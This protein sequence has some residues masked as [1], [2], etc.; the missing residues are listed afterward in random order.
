LPDFLLFITAE[1]KTIKERYAKKNELDDF[2]EDQLESLVE[3]SKFNKK[4]RA[5][6]AQHFEPHQARVN[7]M[8]L[9]T[10][11]SIETTSKELNNKFSPKVI[12]VNH[13]KALAV[14]TTCANIAIKYNMVYI[15][16]YQVIKHHIQGNT[17]WGKRLVAGQTK[18]AI[19]ASLQVR[20]EF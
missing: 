3:D 10:D 4:L 8:Q 13:E 16:A 6:L 18:K 15:S 12:L 20:D 14:D 19:S 5:D 7:I 1:E 9:A 17:G 11:S 2:P